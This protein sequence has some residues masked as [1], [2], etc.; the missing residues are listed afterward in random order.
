MWT[1]VKVT[2]S[3]RPEKKLMAVFA[4]GAKR[5]TVHFGAAGY[6]D[7]TLYYKK[8]KALAARK[9]AS[10]IRRHGAQERWDDPT[11]PG[12]LS[13]FILW[14]EPTV[15]ASVSAFKTKFRV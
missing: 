9:K 12:A 5:K 3:T 11:T 10:Y 1:L 6:Q 2:K 14:N 7:Y 4:D 15:T 8:D 13:R